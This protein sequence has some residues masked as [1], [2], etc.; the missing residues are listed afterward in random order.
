MPLYGGREEDFQLARKG[1]LSRGDSANSLRLNLT[2]HVGTHFDFPAHVHLGGLT[3]DDYPAEFFIF[4]RPV[5]LEIPLA[6]GRHLTAADLALNQ[7]DSGADLILIRT[8]FPYDGDGYWRD[9]PGLDPT[10]AVF[11]KNLDPPPRAVGLDF[12]SVNRWP[13]RAPGRATHKI[14]LAEPEILIIEDMDLTPLAGQGDRL[15]RVT[16]MPLRVAGADGVPAMVLGEL[17]EPGEDGL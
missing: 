1:D 10:A 5:L 3:L 7:P 8:G 16:A 14:L 4:H 9:N 11:F 15:I 13:D 17:A 6:V 2:N 12:I